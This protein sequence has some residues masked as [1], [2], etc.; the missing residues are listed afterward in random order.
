MRLLDIPRFWGITMLA[1]EKAISEGLQII[2]ISVV[3]IS[4]TIEQ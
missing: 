2:N 4:H 3:L 1:Q